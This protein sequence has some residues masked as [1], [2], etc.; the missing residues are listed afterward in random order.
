M[1]PPTKLSIPNPNLN[2]NRIFSKE[3]VASL[4]SIIQLEKQLAASLETQIT[5]AQ[6]ACTELGNRYREQLAILE[7][8]QSQFCTAKQ[9]LELLRAHKRL[10]TKSI[11]KYRSTFHPIL[12]LPSEL[13]SQIFEHLDTFDGGEYPSLLEAT[14]GVG[15]GRLWEDKRRV[16]ICRLD[17]IP[18]ISVLELNLQRT[19]SHLEIEFNKGVNDDGSHEDEDGLFH[20]SWTWS[21]FLH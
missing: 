17:E 15:A 5:T 18:V 9:H 7:S 13:L 16:N 8:I 11:E 14:R 6:V 1:P 21:A 3:E 10:I 4:H 2:T 19:L 20:K 12:S